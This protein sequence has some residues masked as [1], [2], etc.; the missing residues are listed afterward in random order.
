MQRPNSKKGEQVIKVAA[1][2]GALINVNANVNTK[3]SL[4]AVDEDVASGGVGSTDA[5]TVA[6]RCACTA[7]RMQLSMHTNTSR[8]LL[9]THTHDAG[10]ARW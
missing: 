3:A 9:R 1:R 8:I 2:K 6:R 10:A 5:Q 7:G 4:V